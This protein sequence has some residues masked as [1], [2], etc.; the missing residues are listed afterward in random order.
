MGRW[1]QYDEDS[2]RLPEGFKRVGYDADR[3]KYIFEDT[4]GATWEGREGEEFGEMKKGVYEPDAYRPP[5]SNNRISPFCAVSG[6]SGRSQNAEDDDVEYGG[7][8]GRAD[9]YQRLPGGPNQ[10]TAQSART[11]AYRTIFPFFLIIAVVLLLV[12]RAVSPQ[13]SR[14]V[15][16]ECVHSD[17]SLVQ[18]IRSGDTCWGICEDS[19]GKHGEDTGKCLEKLIEENKLQN[20][21]RGINCDR[22]VA[23]QGICVPTV[24]RSE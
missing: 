11:G 20:E 18:T 19:W 12:L 15:T 13:S 5:G 7:G 3:Q 6:G 24:P 10:A 2:Y 16:P 9:G 23:G 1:T 4:A 17:E 21:G 14:P 22:L 8:S